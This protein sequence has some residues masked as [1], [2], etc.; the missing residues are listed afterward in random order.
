MQCFHAAMVKTEEFDSEGRRRWDCECGVNAWR[1]DSPEHCQNADT[2]LKEPMKY[3]GG[4]D[5]LCKVCLLYVRVCR[6]CFDVIPE[7]RPGSLGVPG[8]VSCSHLKF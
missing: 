2:K 7:G 6:G 4:L 5:W 3:L 8:Q 1:W